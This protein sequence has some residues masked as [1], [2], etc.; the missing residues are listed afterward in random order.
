MEN[1]CHD[2]VCSKCKGIKFLVGGLI[3]IITAMKWGQEAVWIAVG[4]MVIVKGLVTLAMPQ[5]CGHCAP[6]GKKKR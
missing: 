3:I 6:E 1:L 5:G 2:G 4:A